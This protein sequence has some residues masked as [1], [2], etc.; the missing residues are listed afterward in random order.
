MRV[1]TSPANREGEHSCRRQL[2]TSN[3][4]TYQS[5][6][7]RGSHRVSQPVKQS[8]YQPML[9]NQVS[10]Q[11]YHTTPHRTRP[12]RTAPHS[13]TLHHATPHRTTRHHTTPHHTTPLH[14]TTPYYTTPHRTTLHHIVPYHIIAYHTI[15]FHTNQ[16]SN[17]SLNS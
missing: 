8:I 5:I 12:Y 6:R 15:P 16:I 13:T 3:E 4:A 1:N 2:T 14:Y 7:P 17:P 10:D 11:T 9:L